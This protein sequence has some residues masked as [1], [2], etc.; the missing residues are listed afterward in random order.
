MLN[1]KLILLT[2]L[3]LGILK[4]QASHYAGIDLTYECTGPGTYRIW[5]TSYWDCGNIPVAYSPALSFNLLSGACSAPTTTPWVTAAQYQMTPYSGST[6]TNCISGFSPI[7]SHVALRQYCDVSFPVGSNCKFEVVS[8]YC[9]RLSNTSAFTG[10]NMVHMAIDT[11][12]VSSTV[13]NSS[14]QWI[15]PAI[16]RVETGRQNVYDQRAIDPDGDSVAYRL[17]A[18]LTAAGTSVAY[19]PGFSPTSPLGAAYGFS[20]DP[21]TGILSITNTSTAFHVSGL[22][23]TAEEWRGGVK[24]GEVHRETAL[25][26]GNPYFL[27]NSNIPTYT[28][29]SERVYSAPSI[30]T[31][32]GKVIYPDTVILHPNT[33]LRLR[34][35]ANDADPGNGTRI[36]W[37]GDLPGGQ[38]SDTFGTPM[39]TLAGINPFARLTWTPPSVQFGT[40]KTRFALMDTASNNLGMFLHEVTIIIADTGQVWPG[41]AN[42]DLTA[43]FLDLFPIGLAYGNTGPARPL[44]TQDNLWYGHVTAPWNDTLAGPLD[45]KYIDSDGNGTIN[46][47]DTLAIT[48]NYG[49]VHTKGRIAARG[50]GADPAL[51]FDVLQD[52]AEVGDTLTAA[53]YLGDAFIPANDVYGIGFQI[54]YDPAAIDSSSFQLVFQPSW[55]GDAS[56]TL[57]ITHNDPIQALCDG[58]QVRKTHTAVSGMG[59]IATATFIIIDNIDGKRAQLDSILGHFFFTQAYLIGLDGSHMPI[60]PLGDS[61][62]VYQLSTERPGPSPVDEPTLYPVPSSGLV[63]VKAPGHAL[64]TATLLDLSGREVARFE[65]Q[66][67]DRLRLDLGA[68]PSGTYF[69]SIHSNMGRFTRRLVLQN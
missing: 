56:N 2:L 47:D 57:S 13:C 44:G 51:V 34:I 35:E 27:F 33:Q 36:V 55:I 53:I 60:N 66:G 37:M 41:D 42:N 24:I 22:V 49:L 19:N 64:Q 58:A 31:D 20:L 21:V 3:L 15:G 63:Q 11:L 65:G 46:D 54:A 59:Q 17:S 68:L 9:C 67:L 5:S 45:K 14:P 30:Y 40:Y 25:F 18:P 7:S 69:L 23:V 32:Y 1:K 12:L 61:L 8:A 43:D 29:H 26:S 28:L 39:D 48:L 6:S 10:N 62:M 38:L 52:S 4:V 16:I 50:S